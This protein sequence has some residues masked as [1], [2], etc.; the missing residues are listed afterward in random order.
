MSQTVLKSIVRGD[1]ETGM[2]KIYS[3]ISNPESVN[4][5]KDRYGIPIEPKKKT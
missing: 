1:D 2:Q 5:V 3:H 4:A